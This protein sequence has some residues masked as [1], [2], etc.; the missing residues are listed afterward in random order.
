MVDAVARAE[1][2]DGLGGVFAHLGG[3]AGVERDAVRRAVDQ[4]D[5]AALVFERAHRLRRAAEDGDRRVV[6]VHGEADVVLLGH[7][8]HALQEPLQA[9]PHLFVRMLAHVLERRQVLGAL[10]V[11][12]AQAAQAAPGGAAVAFGAAQTA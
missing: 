2:A 12:V 1:V 6:G 7:G 9:L 5:E 4:L 10:V 11:V 3:H 8:D